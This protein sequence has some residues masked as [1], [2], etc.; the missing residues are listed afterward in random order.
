M[1]LSEIYVYSSNY[2]IQQL[3]DAEHVSILFVLLTR[4]SLYGI[5]FQTHSHGVDAALMKL[6]LTIDAY[7]W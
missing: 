3:K 7:G 4:S 2:Q 6:S 5:F 1:V